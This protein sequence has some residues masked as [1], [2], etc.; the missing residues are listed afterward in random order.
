MDEGYGMRRALMIYAR[1][2][3]ASGDKYKAVVT[4]HGRGHSLEIDSLSSG[5]LCQRPEVD[6]GCTSSHPVSIISPPAGCRAR[7][8]NRR[9]TPKVR[10]AMS[11]RYKRG[12]EAV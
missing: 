7:D 2:R 1:K 10:C 4:D 12:S 3:F 11:I 8:S 6:I 9:C 5:R